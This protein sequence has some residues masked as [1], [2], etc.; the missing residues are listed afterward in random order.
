[1]CSV[2]SNDSLLAGWSRDPIPVGERFSAPV[3]TVPG[4]LPPPYTMRTISFPG[5]ERSGS[6]VDHPPLS[7]A[8]FN[9]RVEVHLYSPAWA[10]VAFSR[11]TFTFTFYSKRTEPKSVII[12][13]WGSAKFYEVMKWLSYPYKL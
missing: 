3:Q 1:M 12:N 6:G 11:V 10:F 2:L 8:E 13:M 4:F 9:K 5:V 7:G